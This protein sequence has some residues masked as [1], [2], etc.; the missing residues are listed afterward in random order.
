ML[1]DYRPECPMHSERL[2]VL[3]LRL[4]KEK[5]YS[6]L[7]L[8]RKDWRL[9]ENHYG[10]LCL[11]FLASVLLTLRKMYYNSFNGTNIKLPKS[12]T[13]N[14]LF[15]FLYFNRL[16]MWGGP[17]GAIKIPLF[18]NCLNNISGTFSE[19]A[20]IMILSKGEYFFNPLLPSQ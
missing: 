2:L 4:K 5:F 11:N 8:T 9:P 18:F 6:L 20:V 16:C 7:L 3:L 15:F 17:T 10:L 19:A 12:S 14:L 13:S 1:T